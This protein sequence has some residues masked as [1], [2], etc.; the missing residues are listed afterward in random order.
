MKVVMA[1]A[2]HTYLD[3]KYSVTARSSVPASLGMNWACPAGCDV[4]SA[5]DW[6]PGSLVTGVTGKSVLGVEGDIWSETVRTMSDVDY[7]VF[8]RLPA[9]AEVAWS[10]PAQ[11]TAT[12]AAHR[13]FLRRLAAQGALLQAA[14]INFYPST[15]VNWPLTAE[16]AT[17]R[18]SSRGH[19]DATVATLSAPGFPT[20]T[21]SMCDSSL[22]IGCAISWGDGTTS[23]GDVTGS[24]ATDTRVNSLY[25][26]SGEHSYARPGTYHGAVTLSA[27]S[28]KPVTA[29][30][31]VIWP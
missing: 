23:T 18:A 5:Y 29:R 9:L 19:V 10:S 20:S 24:N 26:I 12:S 22:G 25:A 14:G 4:A 28:A 7:L 2:D 16:G 11:R 13:D 3:Q 21:L 31:T 6:D 8:P 1:A 15:E 27:G 17:V 30:F